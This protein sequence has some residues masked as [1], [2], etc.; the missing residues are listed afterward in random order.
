MLKVHNY[1]ICN[2]KSGVAAYGR[3]QVKHRELIF[4]IPITLSTI[5]RADACFFWIYAASSHYRYLCKRLIGKAEEHILHLP[6]TKNLFRL[7][8]TIAL[9]ALNIAQD[10]EHQ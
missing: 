5:L 2:I 3:A 6:E 8:R 7:R 9:D 1:T 4:D 10:V